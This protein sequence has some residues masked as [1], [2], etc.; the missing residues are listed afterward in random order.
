MIKCQHSRRL[1]RERQIQNQ[2]GVRGG[3]IMEFIRIQVPVA[4]AAIVWS[5]RLAIFEF[6][7]GSFDDVRLGSTL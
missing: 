7:L 3:S 2:S 6:V 1:T 5:Q 4:G